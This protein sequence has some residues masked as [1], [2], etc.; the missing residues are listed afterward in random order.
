MVSDIKN[1]SKLS[2]LLLSV[3][4]YFPPVM[5]ACMLFTGVSNFYAYSGIFLSVAALLGIIFFNSF[6]YRDKIFANTVFFSLIYLY[7]GKMVFCRIFPESVK[8]A[9]RGILS[10]Y[11]DDPSVWEQA[12]FLSSLALAVTVMSVMLSRALAVPFLQHNAKKGGITLSKK[13]YLM[14]RDRRLELFIV[15]GTLFVAVISLKMFY[16]KIGQ[17]GVRSVVLPFRLSGFIYYSH[18]IVVPVIGIIF[19]TFSKIYKKKIYFILAC[20]VFI[21][22]IFIEIIVRSSRSSVFFVAI[23]FILF[24]TITSKDS[25]NL[26]IKIFLFMVIVGTISFPFITAYR[27]SLRTGDSVGTVL[28]RYMNA[29]SIEE[30]SYSESVLFKVAT[31]LN[32]AEGL[33]ILIG[34]KLESIMKELPENV[35]LIDYYTFDVIKSPEDIPISRTPG[36]LGNLYM[37]RGAT[38]IILGCFLFSFLFYWLILLGEASWFR[39]GK[40]YQVMMLS[41]LIQVIMG[42]WIKLLLKLTII[43]FVFFFAEGLSRLPFFRQKKEFKGRVVFYEEDGEEHH[44]K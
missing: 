27:Y 10:N 2:R 26:A 15:A 8:Y 1:R 18:K 16:F 9:E 25:I 38:A 19:L 29:I 24:Y 7:H 37:V 31:R 35:K 43:F 21:S 22:Y 20:V 4:F 41:V 23:W 13:I 28:E 36:F 44:R 12:F 6:S 5:G 3:I 40:V 32:G 33:M 30:N 39:S 42:G 14:F 11:I 34:E 17:M